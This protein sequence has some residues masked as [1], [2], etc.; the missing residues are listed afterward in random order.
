MER[1]SKDGRP[2]YLDE[3]CGTVVAK[4]KNGKIFVRL[5]SIFWKGQP[6]T[7]KIENANTDVN[8]R[9]QGVAKACVEYGRISC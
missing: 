9:R 2:F 5:V 1:V 6:H 3:F 8:W 7:V 4:D